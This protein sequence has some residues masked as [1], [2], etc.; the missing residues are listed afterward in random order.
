MST[1]QNV[2]RWIGWITGHIK[3]NGET[4]RR[5]LT[6][7][8]I[9]PGR[10]D[11]VV[12]EALHAGQVVRVRRGVYGLP[13]VPVELVVGVGRG[14]PRSKC[15]GP[16]VDEPASRR[17]A[18]GPPQPS[19]SIEIERI[20][21]RVLDMELGRALEEAL[22]VATAAKQIE[23]PAVWMPGAPP[24]SRLLGLVHHLSD[25]LRPGAAK[26]GT[27]IH[28]NPLASGKPYPRGPASRFAYSGEKRESGKSGHPEGGG[29]R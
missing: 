20:D 1:P 13:D 26:A 18:G 5:D 12:A 9:P 23:S 29:F 19:V 27:Q 16:V 28:Y 4:A 14:R 21:A 3:A 17:Q 7:I 22:N 24:L 8:G 6:R 15:V 11:D 10:L 25:R 2:E